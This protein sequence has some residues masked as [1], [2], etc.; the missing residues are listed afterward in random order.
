MCMVRGWWGNLPLCADIFAP[1]TNAF[2]EEEV[3]GTQ[4]V[5]TAGA[6]V[7]VLCY[8]HPVLLI[9]ITRLARKRVTVHRRCARI[10]SRQGHTRIGC[11]CAPL[12]GSRGADDPRAFKAEG[13]KDRSLLCPLES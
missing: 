8:C 13:F 7:V 12:I 11:V 6:V 5:H 9:G 2:Q 1:E 3:E 4:N 10:G